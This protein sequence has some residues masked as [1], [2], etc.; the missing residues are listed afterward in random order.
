MRRNA[1]K[2]GDVIVRIPKDVSNVDTMNLIGDWH[3]TVQPT[4]LI[5]ALIVFSGLKSRWLLS[6]WSR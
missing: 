1:L 5:L 2:I 3:Q 4:S 6:V